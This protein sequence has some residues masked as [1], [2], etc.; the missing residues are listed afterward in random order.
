MIPKAELVYVGVDYCVQHHGI[1]NEDADRCDFA[2]GAPF[3]CKLR[4]LGYLRPAP[5]EETTP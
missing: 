2:E 5:T 3:P 4:R 1:R